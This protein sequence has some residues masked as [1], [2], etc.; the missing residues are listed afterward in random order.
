MYV[1]L[2]NQAKYKAYHLVFQ[3]LSIWTYIMVIMS[4]LD[5]EFY[6]TILLIT[7]TMLN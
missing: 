1:S 2:K 5:S 4:D 3:I 6:V 7:N